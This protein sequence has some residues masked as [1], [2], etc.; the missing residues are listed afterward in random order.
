ML[1]PVIDVGFISD[2]LHRS[3]VGKDRLLAIAT[4]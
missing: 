1:Y 3:L 4:F 2:N